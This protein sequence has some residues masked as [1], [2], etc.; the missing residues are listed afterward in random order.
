M[1][2]KN[3]VDLSED[4]AFQ[5]FLEDNSNF[6]PDEHANEKLMS[7]D[8]YSDYP[9]EDFAAIVDGTKYYPMVTPAETIASTLAFLYIIDNDNEQKQDAEEISQIAFWLKQGLN[10]YKLPIPKPLAAIPDP[11]DPDKMT[12][13][14][15]EPKLDTESKKELPKL[16]P[17]ELNERIE[18]NSYA[19]KVN[20]ENYLPL[21]G[22]T[23]IVK[24]AG[25]FEREHKRLDYKHRAQAAENIKLAALKHNL[26]LS[27][28]ANL[29]RYASRQVNE[30]TKS[31]IDARLTA[32]HDGAKRNTLKLIKQA[33]LRATTKE[34]IEKL[35]NQLDELDKQSEWRG[36]IDS[37][38]P[39]A[40]RTFGHVK[41]AS[42]DLPGEAVI[43][44]Y[45][46][47]NLVDYY[48]DELAKALAP[49]F[50][51][52]DQMLSVLKN[53]PRG[54]WG[55]YPQIRKPIKALFEKYKNSIKV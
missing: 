34:E 30:F 27:G 53:D 10:K 4:D 32:C 51:D 5:K 28:Y 11:E 48:P 12:S 6:I 42:S 50:K 33:A 23:Q 40:Y 18:K 38:I 14:V 1:E 16:G 44:S 29:N 21:G 47:V 46:I 37:F 7:K 39:D 54:S 45:D 49:F 17:Q 25:I 8:D 35:A 36:Y 26:D 9:K 20:G 55:R 52:T 15:I 19:L 3:Y 24:A 43:S 41:E 31:A 2:L 22:P 13:N